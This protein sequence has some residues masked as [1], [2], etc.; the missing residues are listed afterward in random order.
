MA[1]TE[2]SYPNLTLTHCERYSPSFSLNVYALLHLLVFPL[3]SWPWYN[4]VSIIFLLSLACLIAVI[5]TTSL[6][7]PGVV[8]LSDS[9]IELGNDSSSKKNI[10]VNEEVLLLNADPIPIPV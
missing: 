7:D 10:S 4:P 9:D 8:Q 6:I 5:C 1:A 2:T 3:L